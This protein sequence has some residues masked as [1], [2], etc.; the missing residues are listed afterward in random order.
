MIEIT[1]DITNIVSQIAKAYKDTLVN[2]GKVASGNL[3]NFT[4]NIEQ[5]NKYFSIVFNLPDY[6]KYVENGRAAGKFP[7]IN[8]IEKWITVKP[9]IP[10]SIDNKVPTTH[11]LAFMIARGI[12]NKG[13]KPTRALQN[14]L[15]SQST[16][17]LEDTL[18][19]LIIN[20]LEE[21]INKEEI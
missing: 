1:T 6:W 8:A 17:Q 10:K 11:Q 12:A 4:Y 7:P 13:I 2:A 9:I 16:Q 20:Q 18:C 3:S 19:N 21:E 14:S 5:D 15:N